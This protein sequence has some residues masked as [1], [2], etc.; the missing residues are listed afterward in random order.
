MNIIQ[1]LR[2]IGQSLSWG[3]SF[4]AQYSQVQFIKKLYKKH[5]LEIEGGGACPEQ[6]EVFQ[7]DKNIAY[8]RLRH[9]VFTVDFITETSD[10]EI[11]VD[12]PNGDG[13]FNPNERCKYLSKAM[14]KVLEQIESV[15]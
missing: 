12:Y 10:D 7:N 8:Y 3:K 15:K 9:G 5:G 6:Y 2:R 13:I 11:M 14:R 1:K 4:D